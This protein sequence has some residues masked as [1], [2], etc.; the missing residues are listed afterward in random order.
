MK[1]GLLIFNIVL[2]LL[3]GYLFY[4]HFSTHS[5]SP[6]KGETKVAA[7]GQPAAPVENFRIAY[8]DM[9]SLESSFAMVKDVKNELSK[10]EA[11]IANE[12]SRLD[13]AYRD[14]YS[15]YENQAKSQAMTQ[16]QSEMATR[17]MMQMEQNMRSRKQALDQEYQDYYMRRMRD[18]KLKIEEYLKDYNSNKGFSY[19]L[20]NEPGL[21]YYRDTAYNITRDVINGLNRTYGTKKK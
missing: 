10:K 8:F 7:N 18:V 17:E 12:L 21:I 15:Q 2:L 19:I 13:K 6:K 16:V 20:V 14:R 1:S 4:L 5:A 3:V 9:D 11:S